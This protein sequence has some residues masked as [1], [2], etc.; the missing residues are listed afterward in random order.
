MDLEVLEKNLYKS[1]ITA[2]EDLETSYFK[3]PRLW[4]W[5]IMKKSIKNP[6]LRHWKTLK[7]ILFNI[8]DYGLGSP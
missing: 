4:H 7:R 3:N 2:W 6:R 5:K 8:H 1:T